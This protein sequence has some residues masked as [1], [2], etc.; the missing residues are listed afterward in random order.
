MFNKVILKMMLCTNARQITDE[1]CWWQ[2][3]LLIAVSSLLC[4][5]HYDDIHIE[6]KEGHQD[7]T[8]A[9]NYVGNGISFAHNPFILCISLATSIYLLIWICHRSQ[10]LQ[11]IQTSMVLALVEQT[12]CDR[13]TALLDLPGSP[14]RFTAGAG[15]IGAISDIPKIRCFHGW[16]RLGRIPRTDGVDVNSNKHHIHANLN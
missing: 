16:H 14:L 3:V 2:K 10:Y 1:M 15:E 8:D 11:W 12:T 6:S 13:D 9:A 7:N 4:Y 5:H